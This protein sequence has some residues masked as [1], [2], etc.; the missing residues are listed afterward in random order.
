MPEE[1]PRMDRTSEVALLGGTPGYSQE[2]RC[3]DRHGQVHW[4]LE[5]VSLEKRSHGKWYA[6]AVCTDITER[7]QADEQRALVL[8]EQAAR[9]QAEAA[10][11]AKDQFLAVLSHELRTPLT[12][13]LMTASAL[14]EDPLVPAALRSQVEMIRRN[15][16]LERGSSTTCSTPTASPPGKWN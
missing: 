9:A 12:A 1:S 11:R 13:V 10:S 7:K 4:L 16:E 3:Q 8:A 2:F 14:E 15:V 6:V 5:A